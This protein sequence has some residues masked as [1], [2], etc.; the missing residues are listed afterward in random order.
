MATPV[1]IALVLLALLNSAGQVK[2]GGGGCVL[3]FSPAC[4]QL[5]PILLF[6]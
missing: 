2:G 6:T 4:V 3:T 1:N 5:T